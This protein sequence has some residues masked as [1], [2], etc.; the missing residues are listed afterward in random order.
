MMKKVFQ[1]KVNFKANQLSAINTIKI[2]E[3]TENARLYTK[4][5]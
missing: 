2:L 1:L 5:F 3:K 4:L